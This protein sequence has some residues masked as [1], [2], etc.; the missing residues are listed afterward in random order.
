[1]PE[2]FL[3]RKRFALPSVIM[4][5]RNTWLKGSM[6]WILLV[7]ISNDK[8]S[9]NGIGTCFPVLLDMNGIL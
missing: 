4:E 7:A 3:E 2:D 5:R 9:A 6:E 1:M 8:D